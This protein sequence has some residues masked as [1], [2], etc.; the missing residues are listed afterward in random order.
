VVPG[1]A[2]TIARPERNSALKRLDLPTL[3]RPAI[4]TRAPSRISRWIHRTGNF[5]PIPSWRRVRQPVLMIYG[6]Q[7]TQLN[8]RASIE[9]LWNAIGADAENFSIVL[10]QGNGHA[11]FRED[12]IAM[13]VEWISS[14]GAR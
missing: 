6:G 4:A 14:G 13:L 9:R 5:D 11:L 8:P 7:D 1:F 2:A 10:H 12:V 3:G